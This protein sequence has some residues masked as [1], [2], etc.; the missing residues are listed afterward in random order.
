MKMSISPNLS[1]IFHNQH[2]TLNNLYVVADFPHWAT[3]EPIKWQQWHGL[4]FFNTYSGL[5]LIA[6]Y[7]EPL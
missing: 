2:K 4:D 5:K 6:G 1:Y 3:T 7:S